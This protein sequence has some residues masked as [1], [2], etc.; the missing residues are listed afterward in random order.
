MFSRGLCLAGAVIVLVYRS[1][2]EETAAM[3]VVIAS[4]LLLGAALLGKCSNVVD[5]NFII[6]NI[7]AIKCVPI[8]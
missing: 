1:L 4:L 8:F 3:K 6:I 2:G 7:Y 5:N